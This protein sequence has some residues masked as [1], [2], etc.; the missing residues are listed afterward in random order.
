MCF[1]KTMKDV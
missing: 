1:V